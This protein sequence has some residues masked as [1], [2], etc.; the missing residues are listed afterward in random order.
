LPF[1]SCFIYLYSILPL[2]YIKTFKA[3]PLVS[4]CWMIPLITIRTVAKEWFGFPF[5]LDCLFHVLLPLSQADKPTKLYTGCG[6]G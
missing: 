6:K 2:D 4:C 3:E 5:G 1:S